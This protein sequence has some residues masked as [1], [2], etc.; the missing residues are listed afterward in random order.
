MDATAI[1]IIVVSTALAIIFKLVLFKKIRNW[2]DQDLIKGLAGDDNDK[3]QFL[4]DKLERLK[5]DRVPRKLYQ[6][7]LTNDANEFE[8]SR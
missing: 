7:H 1:V 6:E 8:Q 2:M 3:L 5:S 4:Q